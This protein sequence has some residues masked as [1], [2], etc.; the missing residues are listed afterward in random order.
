MII[1]RITKSEFVQCVKPQ[2]LNNNFYNKMCKKNT[3]I[4]IRLKYKRKQKGVKFKF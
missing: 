2:I 4:Q 1:G 3:H